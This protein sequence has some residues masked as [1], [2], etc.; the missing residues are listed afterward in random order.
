[1]TSGIKQLLGISALQ[2]ANIGSSSLTGV[3]RN[4][5]LVDIQSSASQMSVCSFKI[6]QC[7]SVKKNFSGT[8]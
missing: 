8:T 3:S 5:V 6:S 1:M 7:G 4:K 2:S